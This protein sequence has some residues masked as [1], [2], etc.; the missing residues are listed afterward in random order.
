MQTRLAVV[1]ALACLAPSCG[2]KGGD[3]TDAGDEGCVEVVEEWVEDDPVEEPVEDLAEDPGDDAPAGCPRPGD[4]GSGDHDVTLEHD[5]MTRDYIVHVPPGYD[6]ATPTPLVLNMHG[7]TSNAEQQ[8]PFSNMNATADA[9]GFIALYPDGYENSWNAGVCC[10]QAAAE[11]I[12]DVGF[13]VSVVTDVSGKLCIDPDRVFASGMSNGGYMSHR[14]AC[15]ASDVFAAVAPVAGGLGIVGCSPPRPVPVIMFHGTDDSIVSFD[16]AE[17]ALSAWGSHDSCTSTP[18]TTHFGDSYCDV[19]ETC[20]GGSE[21]GLCALAGMDHCWPGG[22]P[23]RW[24]CETFVGT[25]S[26]DINANDYMWEFFSRH[27]MP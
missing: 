12:D 7:Y 9:E 13:L 15:E 18:V 1:V 16:Q 20:D 5:S 24:L 8:V 11:G 6:P 2:G 21:V 3:G 17:A 10:G 26:V 25:Y 4:L 14:L 27:P 23:P 22:E 19:H